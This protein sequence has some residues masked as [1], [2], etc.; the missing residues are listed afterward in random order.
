MDVGIDM[1][2][3]AAEPE[4]LSATVPRTARRIMSGEVW[5]PESLVPGRN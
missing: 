2:G 5:I 3:T 4:V 1:G